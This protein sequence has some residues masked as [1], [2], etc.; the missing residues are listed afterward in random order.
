MK[1]GDWARTPIA[2]LEGRIVGVV[3]LGA[4]GRRVARLA[5]AFGARVLA[6][7]AGA[8]RGRASAVGARAVSIE[9]LLATA[10]I[11]S[12]NLR[13]DAATTGFLGHDRLALMKPGAILVN[14]ARAALV[15]RDALLGALSSGRLAGAGLD[16]FHDEPLP[17]DDPLRRLPNVVLTPHI[18]GN[19]PEVIRDGLALAVRNVE[20]FLGAP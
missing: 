8:D 15:D 16:V 17:A 7:T 4:I 3:G 14:T 18:A 6:T 10:D 1:R 13:L 20:Q 19:T 11:V 9:E 5:D 12:L 2:Q